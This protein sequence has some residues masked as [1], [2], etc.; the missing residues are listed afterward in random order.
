M[1]V[2][3]PDRPFAVD[4]RGNDRKRPIADTRFFMQYR[5]MP[6]FFLSDASLRTKV[7]VAAYLCSGVVG[8]LYLTLIIATLFLSL[9][10]GI[11]AQLGFLIW[12]WFPISVTICILAKIMMAWS[13]RKD[14][15]GSKV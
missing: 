12:P 11:H 13:H 15:G 1:T 5:L 14:A 10:F 3:I 8:L 2:P 7:L 4:W 9:A 6:N